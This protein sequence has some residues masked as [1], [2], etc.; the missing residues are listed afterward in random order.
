MAQSGPVP[1]QTL[2]TSAYAEETDAPDAQRKRRI[3]SGATVASAFGGGGVRPTHK[4]FGGLREN[5]SVLSQNGYAPK[6]R[7][8]NVYVDVSLMHTNTKPFI[9][10]CSHPWPQT[11]DANKGDVARTQPTSRT[12]LTII[13]G[14]WGHFISPTMRTIHPSSKRRRG[15]AGSSSSL[16]VRADLVPCLEVLV[17]ELQEVGW[18]QILGPVLEVGDDD[19][20]DGDLVAVRPAARPPVGSGGHSCSSGVGSNKFMNIHAPEAGRR[21]HGTSQFGLW[22]SRAGPCHRSTA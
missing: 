1:S 6:W 19:K 3:P 4:R 16:V 12:A 15:A 2:S 7:P 10:A 17:Q 14:T 11:K 22:G 8:R 9:S 20:Q 18:L 13:I 5:R 21:T